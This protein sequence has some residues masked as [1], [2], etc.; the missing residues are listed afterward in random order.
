MHRRVQRWSVPLI[1]CCWATA[2][3]TP[4]DAQGYAVPET[5]LRKN[6]MGAVIGRPDELAAV[7][8]NPAG[9][10][11]QRGTQLY[12]S[13]ASVF[14]NTELRLRPWTHSSDFLGDPVD[15]ENY[16]PADSPSAFAAIP[17]LVVSTEL[18]PERLVGALSLYVPNAAGARFGKDS[19]VRYHL[20]DA[21][22]FAGFFT[23]TL[24]YRLA[25]WM[26]V[27]AGL[28][29]AYVRIR[30]TR[31]IF[32]ADLLGNDLSGLLGKRSVLEFNGDDILPVAN[33]GL[34]VRPHS[35]LSLGFA[36][37]SGYSPKLKGEVSIAFGDDSPLPG[38]V[39]SG[40]QTTT[41]EAPWLFFFGANWDVT[42][43]LEV[44]AELR[45]YLHS[46][47]KEQVTR[48]EIEALPLLDE[49]RQLK[50][51]RDNYQVSGGINVKPLEGHPLELMAGIHFERAASP[52]YAI[53]VE[54]PSFNH[55]GAHGG[56]RYAWRA[57]RIGLA[58]AHYR[59]LQRQTEHSVTFPPTNFI[60]RGYSNLLALVLERRFG[61]GR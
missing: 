6:A 30:S 44:G 49:L 5:G 29:L 42:R 46:V 12:A 28:S 54:A 51:W 26:Q 61:S 18:W 9:L 50:N 37:V 7:Y 25:P 58:F 10:A 39:F 1:F 56:V 40:R 33:F 34:L 27:G 14:I 23:A 19:V 11:L 60:G 53:V 4:A 32:S 22:I 15:A 8:H 31:L 41:T 2:A 59:Y 20:L 45:Y 21:Y 36:F 16:Y 13:V 35:S 48:L 43:W 3:P 17:M 38:E 55:I 24:A 47:V 57:Y 52:S